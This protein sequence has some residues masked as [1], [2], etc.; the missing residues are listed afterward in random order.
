MR[1]INNAADRYLAGESLYNIA[2]DTPIEYDQLRKTFKKYCGDSWTISF[3]DNPVTYMVPRILSAE[4]EQQVK[5]RLYFNRISSSKK[6]PNRYL[7]AGFIRCENCGR[8]LKGTSSSKAGRDYEYYVHDNHKYSR[9]CRIFSA[10]P[11]RQIERAV[12]DTIF[13]S[14]VDVP[15]FEKAIAESLPDEKMIKD[16]ESDIKANQ[17][18]LKYVS[19][20]LEKLVDLALSGTLSKATIHKKEQELIQSRDKLTEQIQADESR[21]NSLPYIDQVREEAYL[22]RRELLEHY[23]SK[24]HIEKMSLDEKRELLYWLFNGKNHLGEPYAIYVNKKGTRHDYMVD[25]FMY[26]KVELIRTLKG[27]NID[28]TDHLDLYESSENTVKCKPRK[29]DHKFD[30]DMDL[31][32]EFLEFM[33]LPPDSPYRS[34][35][36]PKYNSETISA[37]MYPSRA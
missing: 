26:G 30:G 36:K 23:G 12:F 31:G 20:E 32:P 4:K 1:W 27:D 7:L 33:K 35:R 17:K 37:R 15:N 24:E 9:D 29:K 5:D 11:M 14:F 10:I 2:E 19:K 28:Y 13:E 18:K 16:L 25:Y 21:L 6:Q 22:I 8:S 3:K 34:H